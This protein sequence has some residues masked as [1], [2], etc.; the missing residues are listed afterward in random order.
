MA[1]SP[2]AF[3]KPIQSN[4]QKTNR[5]DEYVMRQWRQKAERNE[6]MSNN[7]TYVQMQKQ[8]TRDLESS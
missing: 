4:Q 3:E 8:S 1:E 7:A 5:N 2:R 6:P